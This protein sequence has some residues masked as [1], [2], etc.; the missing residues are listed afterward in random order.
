[1]LEDL[2]KDKDVEMPKGGKWKRG[3]AVA[4]GSHQT[5]NIELENFGADLSSTIAEPAV[6]TEE[7]ELYAGQSGKMI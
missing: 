6:E 7:V 3:G 2:E 4:G 1:M 5:M